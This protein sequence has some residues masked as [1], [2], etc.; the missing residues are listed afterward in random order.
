MCGNLTKKAAGY[1]VGSPPVTE[2]RHC[3]AQEAIDWLDDPRRCSDAH[4][5]SDC[6]RVQVQLILVQESHCE[7]R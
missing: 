7:A 6:G 3:I 4:H 1:E 5:H 2:E